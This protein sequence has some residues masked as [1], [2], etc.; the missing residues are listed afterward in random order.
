MKLSR[1]VWAEINLDNLAHNMREVR[2]VT[3]KNAKVTAV[4]KAD[5]YGHGALSIGSVLLE[6][7]ADRFA[8]ATLSEA[9]QLRKGFPNT[10]IMVLGY[11]PNELALDIINNNIIQT[12]YTKEQAQEYSKVALTLNKRVK[13]H[14]KLDTG[15]SRLGMV[16]S[17]ETIESILDMSKLDGL[18]IEG[19]FTHFAVADEID[20]TFTFKQVEKFNHIVSKLEARG[21]NIPIKH[22]SNSAGII[23]LPEF[24]FDMVR[25]GIMLY[26]L[27][28]SEHVSK[29]A[30]KLREVMCL[31]AKVSQVKDL[32][33]NC[34][35]SYGLKYKNAKKSQIATLP[36]GYADGYTRMLS[37][38]AKVMIRGIK[39]PII[40]SICM[41]QCIID[42]TNFD[43]KVGDEVVLFGGNDINGITI[44]SVAQSLN[45][46]NY[47]IVCM[48]D[49]R[50]PR[51]YIKN[52]KVIDIK[53]YVLMLSNL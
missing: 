48:V 14:I 23:D 50:V 45:T 40:G 9:I 49:K 11:T 2:R 1:P 46:I 20:K 25:A 10:E 28:P 5:G 17:D 44:D 24:N 19:I 34:G 13:I 47:E 29:S 8:V 15:M 6:N 18:F 52:E 16:F 33:A 43:T 41:D 12:I 7:G 27:Y 39:T 31:K 3:N 26:G 53:D 51:V 37:G 21:L 35:V 22:V 4:I 38:K 36:I 30:V 42:V 32:D